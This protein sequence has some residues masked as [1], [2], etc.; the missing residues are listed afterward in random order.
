MMYRADI[1]GLRAIAVLIVVLF[2][3]GFGFFSGGFVGVDVFFVI[4]GF[5]ITSI[6]VREV[7]QGNFSFKRF[8]TRRFKRIMPAFFCV[9][10]ACLIA[11]YFVLLP[12]D[13]VS[14]SK[15]FLSASLF[16]SNIFFWL[17]STGYFGSQTELMPLLHTWTLSVEEQFYFFWPLCLMASSKWLSR[18]TLLHLIVATIV[19]SFGLAQWGALHKPGP[20]FFLLPTRTGELFLGCLMA[21]TPELGKKLHKHVH[22]FI[23]ALGLG[24]IVGSALLLDG[25]S[26]FPGFYA[27]LPC[28]GA[29]AIIVA[30]ENTGT[31]V[32]KL[33]SNRV[34]VFIGLIS[35]SYYLWHWPPI[36]LLNYL[37]IPITP[38]IGAAVV[39]GSGVAAYASWKYVEQPFRY[40]TYPNFGQASARLYVAPLCLTALLAAGITVNGG[41]HWRFD[42]Q[43]QVAIAFH[44]TKNKVIEDCIVWP[45]DIQSTL[46]HCKFGASKEKVD[47]FLAGDSHAMALTGFMEKLA[48][49]AG[50]RMAT[51]TRAGSPVLL[52]IDRLVHDKHQL[53]T[54]LTQFNGV[55]ADALT[56]YHFKYVALTGRYAQYLYGVKSENHRQAV[57]L[58]KVR[59]QELSVSMNEQLFRQALF[60]NVAAIIASGA[61]PI[62]VEDVP[63]YEINTSKCTIL[64]GK[65]C[66]QSYAE[67]KQRQGIVAAVFKDIRQQYPS[68]ILIDLK[69]I[70][71]ADNKCSTG[72]GRYPYYVDTDHLNY[73]A[74]KEI[75]SDYISKFGNPIRSPSDSAYGMLAPRR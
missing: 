43:K 23:A 25:Q 11:F 41:F 27:L 4:S 2:H 24:L 73:L 40:K 20:T 29:C 51:L 14:L 6:I 75:A 9:G 32:Y 21:M 13:Y 57:F 44:E 47:L 74:S 49:D 55:F 16:S 62:L 37:Q 66:F 59:D 65:N 63:E 36:A 58:E 64:N 3:A 33:L 1:D 28:L 60:A 45:L 35:Y 70:I 48:T 56:H 10:F 72:N 46:D 38:L 22:Q 42:Q 39:L 8:Y 50:L 5:L 30:G 52:G 54:D 67:V 34:M 7:D 68:T 12:Q 26:V 71:C 18:K 61:T 15:S 19:V 53:R 31:L 17:S 69:D